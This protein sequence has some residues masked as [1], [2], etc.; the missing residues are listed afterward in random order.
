MFQV[1][2]KIKLVKMGADPR[3]IEPGAIGTITGVNPLFDG[4]VQLSVK[5]DNG[6][7]LMLILPH[8]LVEVINE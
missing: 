2:Q 5:W 4:E 1:G 3:P 6:R 8:D 7:G